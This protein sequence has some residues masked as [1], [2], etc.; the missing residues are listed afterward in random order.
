MDNNKHQKFVKKD[1]QEDDN[2]Q[3][4]L[5]KFPW[6]TQRDELLQCN[7]HKENWTLKE[8]DFS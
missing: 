8:E 3:K 5:L 7:D 6:T 1:C 2:K 4:T